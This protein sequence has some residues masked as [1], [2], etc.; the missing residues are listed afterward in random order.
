MVTNDVRNNQEKNPSGKPE[1]KTRT[2]E[3]SHRSDNKWKCP[4]AKITVTRR[5]MRITEQN[6][7][8]QETSL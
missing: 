7:S 1:T 8:L 5:G 2:P 3:D 6:G 4:E